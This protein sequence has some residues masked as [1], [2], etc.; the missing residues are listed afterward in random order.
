MDT[1]TFLELFKDRVHILDPKDPN[2]CWLWTGRVAPHGYGI[3]QWSGK[4]AR[5]H[6]VAYFYSR[7]TLPEDKDICHTCDNKLCVNPNHLWA[8]SRRENNEDRAKKGRSNPRKGDNHHWTKLTD[9]QIEEIR[10]STEVQRVLAEK[11]GVSQPYISNIQR[12]LVRT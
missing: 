1:E 11:Y 3:L 2:G 7:W 6:R 4:P 9:A 8:G 5:A 10:N 12:G